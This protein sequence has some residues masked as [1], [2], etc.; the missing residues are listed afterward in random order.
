VDSAADDAAP[1]ALASLGLGRL[2]GGAATA[3]CHGLGHALGAPE[4]ALEQRLKFR[5]EAP[6]RMEDADGDR[7]HSDEA[8][9]QCA[10]SHVDHRGC[11][12]VEC[13]SERTPLTRGT[14]TKAAAEGLAVGE[15]GAQGLLEGLAELTKLFRALGV[16]VWVLGAHGLGL[17]IRGPL[18]ERAFPDGVGVDLVGRD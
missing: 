14:A 11:D 13:H 10:R 1:L 4:M 2:V 3:A 8:V 5:L 7:P 15:F 16:D 17:N 18:G 9:E 6:E 12:S